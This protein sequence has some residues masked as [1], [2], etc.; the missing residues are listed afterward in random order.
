MKFVSVANIDQNWQFLAGISPTSSLTWQT[1]S[2]LPRNS[3]ERLVKRPQISLW[4]AAAEG[5]RIA[6]KSTEPATLVSHSPMTAATTNILRKA[7]ASHVRQIAFSF[8]FTELP[9]GPR[10]EFYRLA[11]SGIDQ[12]VVYSQYEADLY[13]ETL[14]IP[15]ERIQFLHWAMDTPS[16][17]AENPLPA[18]IVEPGYIASIGGEGRDYRTFAEAMRRLPHIA[19]VVVGRPYALT[20]IDFPPNV[21]VL[22]NLPLE[23]TWRIA[24]DSNGMV[25]PLLSSTTATGHI[26]MV[27]AQLLGLPL[28]VTDSVGNIDYATPQN[29]LR[30]PA[31]NVERMAE[32]IANLPDE[33]GRAEL[34]KT[35]AL[36]RSS[37]L[38][39]VDYFE[40]YAAKQPSQS[41]P[42]SPRDREARATS[43]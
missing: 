6:G 21:Q 36:Q 27:G 17:A 37:P 34:A 10:A 16:V 7:L 40:R 35:E 26:T 12:F 2:G 14:N 8:N 43:T 23:A 28:A 11:L 4:R 33:T 9:T 41:P 25:I 31:G 30:F 19:A 3:L 1:V 15:R 32:A 42:H 22:S 18:H 39:L 29:S 5:A 24:H 13:S 20:G 38:H